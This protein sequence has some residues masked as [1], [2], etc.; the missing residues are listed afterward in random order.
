MATTTCLALEYRRTD[1]M[2][3]V[4]APRV[5]SGKGVNTDD[6]ELRR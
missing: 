5:S 2:F 1:D 3:R 6:S 4:G